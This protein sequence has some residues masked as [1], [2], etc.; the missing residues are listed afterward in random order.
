MYIFGPCSAETREQVLE[1]ARLLKEECGTIPFI[2]RAGVWKPRT[3]PDTFQGAGEEALGW[4]M[5]VKETY[6]L[7]VATEVATPDHVR[8]ALFAGIDYLWIGARTGANPITVQTIADTIRKTKRHPKGVLVKNPVSEDAALWLGNIERIEQTGVPV[9]AVHRGC[10]HQPCWSMAHALRIAKPELPLLIDPSHMSGNADKIAALLS[11]AAELGYDGSM[12]EIH[13]N[14][15]SALSDAKQQLTPAQYK[16]IMGLILY[17]TRDTTEIEL[18]WLR[19]EI[20]ELD[21]RLWDTIAARMDVSRRIGEWKKTRGMAPLQPQRYQ[22]I[23]SLREQWADQHGLS[24]DF[25]KELFDTI[26]AE[27]VKRQE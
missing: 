1:T 21:D 8:T 25:A 6:G 2:Y 4:L 24:R 15:S 12:I 5:E 19:A 10:N 26:H 17:N 16:A 23:L 27:S 3:S 22:E 9:I 14:P 7:R 13:C 18:R 11:K 20:D